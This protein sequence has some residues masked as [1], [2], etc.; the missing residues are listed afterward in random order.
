MATSFSVVITNYNYK[1]YVA[2][3]IERALA[4]TRPVAQ[5]VVVDDGSTDGSDEWLKQ[6]YASRPEVTLVFSPNRGQLSGFA[7]GT[8]R[9]T[10]DVVCFLDADD[11]WMPDYIEKLGR[12]YDTR[13]DVDFVF[14]DL[15]RFGDADDVESFGEAEEDLG[16]TAVMTY[17]TDAWYGASTSGLSMR[18][19]WAARCVDLPEPFLHM[20]KL[21]A[22]A[23]VV[24]A[25]S[26]FGA[27]KYFLPT[28]SVRY[29]VHGKNGWHL[30]NTSASD[31]RLGLNRRSTI[32]YCARMVG[33][34]DNCAYLA[35]QE[36]KTKPSPSAR[37]I[38]RYL[39]LKVHVA[40]Y[41]PPAGAAIVAPPSASARRIRTARLGLRD[42]LRRI[43]RKPNL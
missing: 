32:N 11:L 15:H 16:Y 34:E 36:L 41:F 25:A 1:R 6:H 4:Q 24:L 35:G 33:M 26:I 39:A 23:C 31:F 38:E 2:E 30:Q 37:E 21:C 14:S 19:Y 27:R 8:A 29:R 17:V 7:L 28:G 42:S 43:L 5:I 18:R 10:G 13:P 20:W 40:R 9:C 22:D 3:A 12:L